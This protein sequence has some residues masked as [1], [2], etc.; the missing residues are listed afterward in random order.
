M[1]IFGGHYLANH[2]EFSLI[3]FTG[4]VNYFLPLDGMVLMSSMI[5]AV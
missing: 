5:K 2:S 1:N 3:D 4:A